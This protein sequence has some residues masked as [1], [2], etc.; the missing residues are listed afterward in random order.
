MNLKK[1]ME[2]YEVIKYR[3]PKTYP[4]P[5]LAFYE[6]EESMLK[7]NSIK[8]E[9]GTYYA[10][11]DPDTLTINLPLNMSFEFFKKNNDRFYRN[12]KLLSMSETTIAHTLL[13]E[14]AHLY[15]G[16]RYGYDSNQYHNEEYCD[17]FANR[18]IKILKEEN[19]I[20]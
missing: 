2:V 19:F 17:R 15:A 9:E 3:L 6:D 8:K 16:N 18:W 7:N 4:R 14:I 10:C 1:V 12:V 13:H 11:V 20:E 5:K